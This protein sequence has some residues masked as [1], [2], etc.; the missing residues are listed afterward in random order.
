MNLVADAGRFLNQ[1][2]IITPVANSELVNMKAVELEF[3][4]PLLEST[5]NNFAISQPYRYSKIHIN[6]VT[7]MN[8]TSRSNSQ[9]ICNTQLQLPW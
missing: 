3:E 4:L 2:L 6:E 8:N 9:V 1:R 7:C 5:E